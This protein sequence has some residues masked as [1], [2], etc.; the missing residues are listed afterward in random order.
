MITTDIRRHWLEKQTKSEPFIF[1]M[2]DTHAEEGAAR[3]ESC[4]SR[5]HLLDLANGA[6]V[7]P[8]VS[9]ENPNKSK[10]AEPRSSVETR[11]IVITTEKD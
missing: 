3:C 11:S 2:Y 1:L 7:C 4:T 6:L 10:D 9:F 5:L 8:H